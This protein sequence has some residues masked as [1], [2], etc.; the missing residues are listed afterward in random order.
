MIDLQA[1]IQINSKIL[2]RGAPWNAA[3][4]CRFVQPAPLASHISAHTLSCLNSNAERSLTVI[5][6]S[7]AACERRQQA[8][9]VHGASR[10]GPPHR[11]WRPGVAVLP[12]ILP[13]L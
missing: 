6:G 8:A 11:A 3:A 2:R 12:F 13:I 5:D 10:F 1:G 9:A 4:C 7:R